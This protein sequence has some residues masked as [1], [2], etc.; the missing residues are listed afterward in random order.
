MV[1]KMR[2]FVSSQND[3]L[4]AIVALLNPTTMWWRYAVAT[5][6][7]TGGMIGM[8]YYVY[9]FQPQKIGCAPIPPAERIKKIAIFFGFCFN[10]ALKGKSNFLSFAASEPMICDI[11]EVI[12]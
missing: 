9:H 8:I 10:I 2:F 7:A 12:L 1:C 5:L 6:L 3:N 4:P 11:S